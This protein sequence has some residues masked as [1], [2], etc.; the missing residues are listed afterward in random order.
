[1]RVFGIN[2]VFFGCKQQKSTW[3]NYADTFVGK[4][5]DSSQGVEKIEELGLDSGRGLGSKGVGKAG[6]N[7]EPHWGTA[8]G[9]GSRENLVDL[10]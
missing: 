6:T 10:T 4:I 7:Q 8:A 3:T 2:L 1:M 5:F 9:R